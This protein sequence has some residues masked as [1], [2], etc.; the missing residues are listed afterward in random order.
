M[1]FTSNWATAVGTSKAAVTDGGKWAGYD[2]F[3]HGDG[4][5]LLSVVDL[6]GRRALK[7]LQRGQGYA[8]N[9][10]GPTGAPVSTDYTLT[11]AIRNDDTS[12][13]DDHTVTP[14]FKLYTGLTYVKRCNTPSDWSFVM[15]MLGLLAGPATPYP[16]Q[17]WMPTVRLAYRKWYRLEFAVHFVDPTHLQVRPRIFDDATGMLLADAAAFQQ[18]D[19][20]GSGVGFQGRDDW[21][22]AQYYGAGLSFPVDPVPLQTVALGNNG[23]AGAVDTK[24]AWYF[25]GLA[26]T[27]AADVA[28]AVT[29]VLAPGTYRVPAGTTI[30]V[31]R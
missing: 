20:L 16:L 4:T 19:Y 25:A 15:M 7:V 6:D 17:R 30:V 26:L 21:T 18:Q 29:P 9:L 31:P 22:L 2:E 28:P 13:A 1:A 12:P 11:V 24:L 8:A 27:S 10:Y 5:Q 14:D 23:Q 3:N